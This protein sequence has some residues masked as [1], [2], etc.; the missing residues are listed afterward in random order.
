MSNGEVFAAAD[1]SVWSRAARALRGRLELASLALLV[2]VAMGL[3]CFTEVAGLVT[4]GASESFDS[5]LMHALRTAG[6]PSDPWGPRWFEEIG[7]DCTAL[8][9]MAVLTLLTAGTVAFLVLEG[10]RGTALFVLASIA[11]GALV[12]V[13]LK[14][15][16]DRPRP[17]L[18]PHLSEVYSASFPSGH[19]MMS[20]LTY[21]TLAGLLARHQRRRRVK[22]FLIGAAA[23]LSLLVGASRVYLG[24]HYPTDVLA[25]WAA[26]VTW[27]LLCVLVARGLASRGGI[28]PEEEE[29]DATDLPPSSTVS[30]SPGSRP[31]ETSG[32]SSRPALRSER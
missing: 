12:G 20:T 10:R 17:D 5:A 11:L 24:V 9:G 21:F 2:A 25:G 1:A 16:F 6:D 7:R 14:E 31:I 32:A 3:W 26:G 8:G 28:E 29:E 30:P 13:L 22:G 4:T 15:A 19:T 23:L 18:V 27:A